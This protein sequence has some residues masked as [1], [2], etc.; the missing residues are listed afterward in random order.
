MTTSPLKLLD[1]AI[2]VA[3]DRMMER[4]HDHGA[5]LV[6]IGS[7]GA[8]YLVAGG[9]KV[10]SATIEDGAVVER[11][12]VDV[13]DRRGIEVEGKAESFEAGWY[14]HEPARQYVHRLPTVRRIR[15]P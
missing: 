9:A 12:L 2:A 15:H 5:L 13:G 4:G 8:W 10:F 6:E 7:D 11:W 14:E 1:G 3:A